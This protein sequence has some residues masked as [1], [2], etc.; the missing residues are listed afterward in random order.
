MTAQAVPGVESPVHARAKSEAPVGP[1]MAE[2]WFLVFLFVSHAYYSFRWLLRYNDDQTSPT[3]RNTP[4]TWQAGKYIIVLALTVL[5]ITAS[6]RH[7]RHASELPSSGGLTPMIW[8]LFIAMTC[9]SLSSVAFSVGGGLSLATSWFFLPMIGLLPVVYRGRETLRLILRTIGLIAAYHIVFSVIELQAYYRY[10]RL[11]ALAYA[12]SLVRFGAGLDDPN[13]F[14]VWVILPIMLILAG[15]PFTM[16]TR[17]RYTL[18]AVLVGLLIETISFS[19]FAGVVTGSLIYMGI[20]SSIRRKTQVTFI[21]IALAAYGYFSGF[22]ATIYSEKS[23]S[24]ASRFDVTAAVIGGTE[25]FAYFLTHANWMSLLLG[26]R[27]NTVL[28]ETSYLYIWGNFGIVVVLLMLFLIFA[29]FRRGLA[30]VKSLRSKGELVESHIFSA[31]VSYIGAFAVAGLGVPVFSVFPTNVTFW[32]VAMLIWLPLD[33]PH[34][35]VATRGLRSRG[36]QT[37]S[38]P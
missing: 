23:A 19:A 4:G 38:V 31:F 25:N 5:C 7:K 9:L 11:P 10:G 26:S 33:M 24:A 22:F 20:N 12:H 14:G 17:K 35:R 34:V 37:R 2:R 6:L 27:T 13:G 16:S 30:R 36:V 3:Y 15:W 18:L 1:T 29:T 8:F 28:S 32:L 21:L